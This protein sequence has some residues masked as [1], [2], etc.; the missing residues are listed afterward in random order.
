MDSDSTLVAKRGPG[1]ADGIQR[2]VAEYPHRSP[3]HSL[4]AVRRLRES[5]PPLPSMP[6]VAVVGT[7]GKTS[8]ATYLARLLSARGVRVG[9]YVSPH[10]ADWSERVRIDGARQDLL[11]A[12][13]QVHE[14]ARA[15]EGAEDLRFFDV[16]TLAAERIFAAAGA[17]V[18]VFEAGIGGR[19]DAVAA[20]DP[21]LALLTSVGSDHAEIL[22]GDPADVLE[23]KLLVVPPGA[24]VI[25]A[26]L[27]AELERVAANVARRGGFRISW[28]DVE[29]PGKREP[30]P[31]LPRYLRSALALAEAG[32]RACEGLLE[33]PA[34]P[35]PDPAHLD[36]W[37]PGRLEH[38]TRG[39][40]P[41]L[42]D[43]A[44]NEDAWRRLAAE[45]RLSS[46]GQPRR[47]PIVALL[48][49]SP[50]KRRESLPEALRSLPGLDSALVTR[51]TALPAADPAPIAA[52][53]R[54]AGVEATPVADVAEALD[55]ASAR[56]AE[57]EGR[58][59]VLGSTHLVGEVRGLLGLPPDRPAARRS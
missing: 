38:G 58:V 17:A 13:A 12:L 35:A 34:G 10:L 9:L 45:L 15:S 1:P 18:G 59:L 47:R 4:D 57:L 43:A 28:V 44:H 27:D 20:L 55:R 39:G 51:H 41:F 19:L 7:N 6:A 11:P 33:R 56:A 3:R 22:G 16:L 8:T 23:E 46:G 25:A 24:T 42:L 31:E 48:S 2:I 14:L 32:E 54:R 40:V 50:D 29:P 30:T 52:E 53:L 49:I 37:L 21:P 36:L 5:L 26:R